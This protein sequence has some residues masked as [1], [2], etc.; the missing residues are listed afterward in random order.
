VTDLQLARRFFAEEIEAVAGLHSTALV[1]ALGSVP[2]ERFLPP[3][4]WSIRS[5]SDVG[6]S[7]RRTPDDDPRRVYHNVA[8]AID[9]ARQLFNGGPSV[10]AS[11]IDAIGLRPGARILHVGCG[12]GYFSAVMAYCAGAS[13]RVVAIDVDEALAAQARS[14]LA[15]LP[16]VDVR[17]GDG[18]DIG[19]ETF[20]AIL[21]NAGTTHPHEAWLT[22][23]APGARLLVPLT[24]TM[25]QMGTIG[26]GIAV[27]IARPDAA[28][29][30]LELA[31]RPLGMV[32]I[33][34]AVGIRDDA[35][36]QQLGRALAASGMFPAITRLRQDAH[37][38]APACWLHGPGWC[39]STKA[40]D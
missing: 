35:I 33:Y 22:A 6:R 14:N 30:T 27:L 5:E 1:D 31:A 19:G 39:L 18:T 3:G 7:V 24:C 17:R 9:P 29:E 28:G 32:A 37:E 20:D 23:L 16:W 2:R 26:K 36:N 11:W 21:V 34:S 15:E 10:L 13:G 38:I 4:P 40:A 12:T 8:I 25:P